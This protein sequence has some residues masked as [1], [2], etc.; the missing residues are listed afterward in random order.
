VPLSFAFNLLS[1]LPGVAVGVR[2][3]VFRRALIPLQCLGQMGDI[4]EIT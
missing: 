2:F 3:S 4:R 1:N